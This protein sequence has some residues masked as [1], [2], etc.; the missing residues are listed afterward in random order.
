MQSHFNTKHDWHQFHTNEQQ[1][2][3]AKRS[4]TTGFPQYAPQQAKVVSIHDSDTS[5]S[6]SL[7]DRSLNIQELKAVEEAQEE[8]P[9]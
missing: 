1:K 4:N 7:S 9:G 2:I 3:L 5:M 6:T 8:T